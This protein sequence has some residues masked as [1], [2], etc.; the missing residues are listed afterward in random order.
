[1]VAMMRVPRSRGALSGIVLLLLGI[2][3]GLVP[4][5]GPYFHYAY[6][7][8]KAW[9]YTTGRLWMNILPAAATVLGGLVV[10]VSIN[11]AIAAAGAWLAAI[12]GI[13]F[14]VGG[15]LSTL[16]T[17]GGHT[18]TGTPIGGTLLR[19]VANIGFFSGLGAVIVFFAALALGRFAVVGIREA[20]HRGPLGVPPQPAVAPEDRPVGAAVPGEHVAR[21]GVTDAGAAGEHVAGPGAPGATP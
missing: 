18:A 12:G 20:A 2:W 5:V 11:R 8:D 14:V 17:A 1:M 3:G 21:P 6:T 10:L 19:A 4:F 7:P 15:V 13:W 16:W 9:A